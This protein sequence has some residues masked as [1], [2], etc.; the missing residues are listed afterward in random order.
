MFLRIITFWGARGGSISKGSKERGARLC[1]RSIAIFRD[2]GACLEKQPH[3][4]WL[5][6]NPSYCHW[7]SGKTQS[8]E[9]L[10]LQTW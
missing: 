10:C 3:V 8:V 2:M 1:A 7:E 5:G 9:S 6:S 4:L